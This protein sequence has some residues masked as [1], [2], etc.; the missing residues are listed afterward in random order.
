M[1]LSKESYFVSCYIFSYVE[2]FKSEHLLYC[3]TRRKVSSALLV[4]GIYVGGNWG[5][6]DDCI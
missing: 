3:R 4:M 5:D 2:I 6:D 1:A